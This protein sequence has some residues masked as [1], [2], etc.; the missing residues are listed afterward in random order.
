MSFTREMK[1]KVLNGGSITIIEAEKL[2]KEPLEELC[3]SANQIREYYCGNTFDICTIINAKSGRC[4]EDCKYCAQSIYYNTSCIEYS[5]LSQEE[6]VEG[7]KYNADRGILRYS[8]VTSGKK[9]SDK[10]VDK[11]CEIVKEIKKEV[12]IRVCGSFGLLGESHYKKLYKSGLTRIHNNLETSQ[13]YFPNMCTTHSFEDK[14]EAIKEAQKAGMTICSGGIF[15]IG[16]TEKDRIELAFALKELGIKSIPVNLLNPIKGTPY[17]ENTPLSE[18]EIKRIVAVYRF[19]LPDSF[20]R[21]AGG[22]GLLEDK[23]RSCFLS[24]AN[25]AISG[26]MLTTAGISI[27][28][29]LKMIKELGFKVEVKNE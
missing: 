23:G 19:I 1:E 13:S 8:L 27:E 18:E 12:S 5:L 25:A 16:E 29:D 17:G 3:D 21:L 20:I 7:A 22:R 10:E 15:G 28:A 11:I 2:L 26:D 4:S 6:I 14:V 9:I 24:G